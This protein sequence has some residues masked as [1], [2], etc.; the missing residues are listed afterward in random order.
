MKT[1]EEH[2]AECKARALKYLETGDTLNA[3]T[4]MAS[5]LE[6]H[7]ETRNHAGNQIGLGLMMIGQLKGVDEM[8][9]FIE[10]YH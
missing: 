3:F 2:V 9:R 5:D 4:S 7:P 1:R 8:R 6:K 10:G